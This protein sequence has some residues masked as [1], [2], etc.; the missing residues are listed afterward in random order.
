ME[1]NRDLILKV[2]KNARLSLSEDEIRQLTKDLNDIVV[3]FSELDKINT[4]NIKPSFQPVD[5]RNNFREDNPR[6]CVP[7]ELI[8]KNCHH[9]KDGYFLGP[10]AL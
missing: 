7:Q 8:L 5:V 6:D 3:A 1:I 9:K 10:R 4:N 2:A